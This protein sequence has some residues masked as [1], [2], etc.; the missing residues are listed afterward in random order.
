M[1][2]LKQKL[3]E[4]INGSAVFDAREKWGFLRLLRDNEFTEE[5]L[6]Q[7]IVVFENESKY[8]TKSKEEYL[9]KLKEWNLALEKITHEVLPKKIAEAE[10]N[11]ATKEQ[12]MENEILNKIENS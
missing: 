4:L 8:Q 2:K 3:R 1:Q 10:K 12:E 5:K 9:L 7:M 6:Q 11:I